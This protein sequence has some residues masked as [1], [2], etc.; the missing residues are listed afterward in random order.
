MKQILPTLLVAVGLFGCGSD[1]SSPRPAAPRAAATPVTPTSMSTAPPPA[2][3]RAIGRIVKGSYGARPARTQI[4]PQ[5]IAPAAMAEARR[6]RVQR[7]SGPAVHPPRSQAE[8]YRRSQLHALEA[9][10]A[11]APPDPRCLGTRVNERVAFP[12]R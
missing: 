9:F 7:S 1:Q 6:T 11:T 3:P 5:P 10:C 8:S 4:P 12:E 2:A